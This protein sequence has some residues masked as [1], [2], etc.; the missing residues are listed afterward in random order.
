MYRR[1]GTTGMSQDSQGSITIT[2]SPEERIDQ[3]VDETNEGK[4]Y[5]TS[6]PYRNYF[7]FLSLLFQIRYKVYTYLYFY[8]PC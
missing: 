6:L 1:S 3:A 2:N 8:K 5:Y 7:A 4:K